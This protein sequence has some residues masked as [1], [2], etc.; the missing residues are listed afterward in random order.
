MGGRS[1]IK[2]RAHPAIL[3]DQNSNSTS[4][5]YRLQAYKAYF[6]LRSKPK[7]QF[8][9]ALV[10]LASALFIGTNALNM[11]VLS[12]DMSLIPFSTPLSPTPN[13][14][15]PLTSALPHNSP[16]SPEP[17][18]AGCNG[19]A[20]FASTA[21]GAEALCHQ[22]CLDPCTAGAA[23]PSGSP[24]AFFSTCTCVSISAVR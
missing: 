8:Q 22:H 23:A 2:T 13:P 14:S 16:R 10:V 4:F 15:S 12:H 20:W 3:S 19:H 5:Q 7:M 1:S 9:A 6:H 17:V 21:A 18:P 11:Y 24:G